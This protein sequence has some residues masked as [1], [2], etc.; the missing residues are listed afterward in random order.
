VDLAGQH[1]AAIS[2][3]LICNLHLTQAQVDE[4][5]TFVKKKQEH[6]QPDDPIDVGDMWIW[7]AIALPSRLRVV[8]HISHERS[9]AEAI[10]FFWL[11]LRHGLTDVHPCSPVTGYPPIWRP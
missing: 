10:T 11:I 7:R 9:E 1:A 5:W 8:S 3:A 4:L 2:T 6:L